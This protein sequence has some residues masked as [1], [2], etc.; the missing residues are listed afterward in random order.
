MSKNQN[1]WGRL[2]SLL[3][4]GQTAFQTP[5]FSSAALGVALA[6]AFYAAILSGWLNH[7]LLKRYAL[8]HLVAEVSVYLFS[9]A[10]VSMLQKLWQARRE[11]RRAARTSAAL[12]E[13]SQAAP[14]ES[15]IQAAEWF[16][17]MW[18]AQPAQAR[19]SWLGQRVQTILGR[20][21]ARGSCRHLEDDLRELADQDAGLQHDSY[22]LVRIIS[23]AMPMFGFLGTVIGISE[24]LG[25]MDTKALASG[26][27][28]A[29]NSLTAG[30]YVA[31]DTTAVGLVLTMAAMFTMFA[32]GRLELQLLGLI[33]RAVNDSLQ[34]VLSDDDSKPQDIYRVEDTVRLM[35]QHFLTAV[36]SLVEKQ[37]SLWQQSLLEAQDQWRQNVTQS[38]ESARQMLTASLDETLNRHVHQFEQAQ[39]SGAAQLDARYQQWQ[40]TLSEQARAIHGHHAQLLQQTSLLTELVEKGEQLKTL[41]EGLQQNLSRLTDIDRFHEVAICLT[42]AVAV[43]GTQMERAGYFKAR[44]AR[45]VPNPPPA[46]ER[47]RR[48]A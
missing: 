17:K 21:T 36:E 3:G 9:I 8:C 16:A 37:A 29:M 11:M 33:D 19:Q 43:L 7:P 40:T 25:Q 48:A 34:G 15:P 6:T 5:F 4:Q 46:E 41:D 10:M 1:G 27:Q 47:L 24:T 12:Q 13:L 35:A 42:E 45:R 2:Q 26:S 28:E 38:T 32:V 31:F 23:W 14:Q 18:Q 44:V 20:Q 39:S 30:L 22:G